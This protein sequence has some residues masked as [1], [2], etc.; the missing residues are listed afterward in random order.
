MKA[1]QLLTVVALTLCV[2]MPSSA[3]TIKTNKTLSEKVLEKHQ[4]LETYHA[5]WS[6]VTNDPNVTEKRHEKSH[7][8]GKIKSMLICVNP[9]LIKK[10]DLISPD[11]HPRGG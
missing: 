4:S 3:D 2:T 11:K 8:M 10:R 1:I 9:W 5:K 6:P 7:L